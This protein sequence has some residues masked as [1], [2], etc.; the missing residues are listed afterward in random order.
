MT[1]RTPASRLPRALRP[2][3]TAQYRLLIAALICSLFS[4]GIWLVASVWQVVELG[5]SAT[6]LSFVAAGAGLGLVLTV[7]IGGAAADRIPQRIILVVVELVRGF[8]YGA[9]A[10][11]A[12][13]GI[14]QVWQL[15]V[16]GFVLGCADGFF[17]PA[18]SAWLPALIEP[19]ELLAANGI[20][21]MLR[22]TIMQAAGPA[23]ASAIIAIW[24]PGVAF[25]TVAVLQ[26]G[27]VAVLFVMRTTPVRR[28]I[29]RTQHPLV[30]ALADIRAGF[31]YMVTTRWLLATLLFATLLVLVVIGPIEVLLPFA[32]K[33][34]TDGGAGAFA[35]ALGS[36]GVGGAIGSLA[37]ASARMPRRYLTIMI[38]S[39]GVGC[40][41]L[42]I[43]GYTDQLWLMVV[44]LFICGFLFSGAQVL[45][46]TLLQRRV[47][48]ALLGR[49]SSL[50]FFVS[51]ALMP[52]SMAVAGPIG[53]SIGIAPAFLIAGVVPTVLAVSTL[54]IARLNSDE[55][56]H[57]L[58]QVEQHTPPAAQ[59]VDP[60]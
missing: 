20:E 31:R 39:W 8:G 49:V 24:S 29:D 25:L 44:A 22:P 38:M 17:Y 40:L 47:P 10:V 11:L 58:D 23:A 60:A 53:D 45:W 54:L 16:I 21:G 6:D 37:M 34:Q 46:G 52:I 50:D 43:I 56:E 12:L 1:S 14:V 2:F 36:F 33:D 15:A 51:L 28:D 55:R 35:V 9:A 57:P 42:A 59:A 7:L 41:P 19:D 5:G 30:G 48:P 27:A 18:Y 4:V 32:V 13:T 26:L 3:A